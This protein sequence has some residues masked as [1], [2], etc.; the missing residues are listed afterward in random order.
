MLPGRYVDVVM[1]FT[2]PLEL[3]G[4][5][6]EGYL[7]MA[8][9]DDQGI[10]MGYI[11][12]RNGKIVGAI[13]EDVLGNTFVEGDMAFLE[14][15][16]VAKKGMIKAVEVYEASVNE[17]L[18]THPKAGTA[19]EGDYPASGNDLSSFLKLLEVHRGG[20]EIYDGSK[21]WA[22]HVEKGLVEAAKSIRG[23]N[24]RGDEAIKDILHEVG[25]L[26][27]EG[28]YTVKHPLGFSSEDQVQRKDVLF[29]SLQLLR[30]KQ[31]LE[32]DF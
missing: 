7:K 15:L 17:L 13:V 23:S 11:M 14:I 22:I 12:T 32:K 6:R 9:R 19:I 18:R 8:W 16:E 21:A 28:R 30:E 31:K 10:K 20:V 4:K 29:E 25:H 1:D 5:V 26:L 3:T 2:D 24:Y 27:R